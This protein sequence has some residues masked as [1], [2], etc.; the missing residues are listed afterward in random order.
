MSKGQNSN[1]TTIIDHQDSGLTIRQIPKSTRKQ[2]FILL[3]LASFFERETLLLDDYLFKIKIFHIRTSK[4]FSKVI[5]RLLAESH[6]KPPACVQILKSYLLKQKFIVGFFPE[7]AK[8]CNRCQK[9]YKQLGKLTTQQERNTLR[10]FSRNLLQVG[11][12]NYFFSTTKTRQIIAVSSYR[13]I[14]STTKHI[15]LQSRKLTE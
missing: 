7:N 2:V 9:D 5:K 4:F 6:T 10:E 11:D 12:S 1:L 15:E 3:T 13:Q 14:K 8:L